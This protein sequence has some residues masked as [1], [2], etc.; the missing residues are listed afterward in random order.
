MNMERT[1]IGG[2]APAVWP[3]RSWLFRSYI[4]HS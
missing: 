3:D 1:L 4:L 2:S